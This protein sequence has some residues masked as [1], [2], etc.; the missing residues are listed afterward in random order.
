MF[1]IELEELQMLSPIGAG[2]YGEVRCWC[3]AADGQVSAA[4]WGDIRVAVKTLRCTL[5]SADPATVTAFEAQLQGL[6]TVRHP[7]VVLLFGAGRRVDGTTLMLKHGHFTTHVCVEFLGGSQI[8]LTDVHRRAVPGDRAS[9]VWHAAST[10]ALVAAPTD[11]AE[12]TLSSRR[13][14]RHGVAACV[15]LRAP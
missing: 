12:A 10:V 9:A 2:T 11:A 3:G 7:N 13:R 8:C 4:V 14:P 15:R 6:L 1:K 5:A